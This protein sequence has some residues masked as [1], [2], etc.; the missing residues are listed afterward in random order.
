ME[1]LM[2]LSSDSPEPGKKPRAKKSA[3]PTPAEPKQTRSRKKVEPALVLHSEQPA[4][5]AAPPD[6]NGM[7]SIAAYFMAAQRGFAPGNELDDWLAAERTVRS[8]YSI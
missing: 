1:A 5:T 2:Q 6:I 4:A 7:I 8:H 3:A